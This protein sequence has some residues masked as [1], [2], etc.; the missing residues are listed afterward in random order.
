MLLR[1]KQLRLAK[2]RP[3]SDNSVVIRGIATAAVCFLIFT[4][5]IIALQLDSGYVATVR[6]GINLTLNERFDEAKKLYQGLIVR[7]TTDCAA[8]LFL[9]GAW[10]AEMFDRE[11]YSNQPQFDSLIE[12]AISLADRAIKENRNPAWAHLAKGNAYAYIATLETR[13]GSWWGAL[14]KGLA[15]KGEYLEVLK[16]EPRLYDTYLGLGSYHY[17]KSAK[18]EFIN[19]IPLVPDRRDEGI[20][21]LQIAVDSS[22]FCNDV[23]ANSL[24]WIYLH[25]GRAGKAYDIAAGLHSKFPDSRLFTWGMAFSSYYCGQLAES[26]DYF[27]K[28]LEMIENQPGQNNF[29]T[30]ECRY[31]RAEI[32][33]SLHQ[34]DR[35]LEELRILL[36]YPLSDDV[37]DRQ[38]HTLQRARESIGAVAG[39][40]TA[41]PA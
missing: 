25:S 20:A 18:T 37:K 22:L 2:R 34:N 15:A 16:L 36:G 17:W 24:V 1:D 3:A 11:D 6:E 35:A 7:D 5:K 38:K 29:N 12:K 4:A 30:V 9:A 39:Q 40:V 14:R 8:Y 32:F 21:E 10:H 19:W 41:L 28:I 23:A 33:H 26:A 13:T 27:G 31:H